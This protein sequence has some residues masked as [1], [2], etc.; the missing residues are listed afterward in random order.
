M[1][2]LLTTLTLGLVACLTMAA[3]LEAEVSAVENADVA[4]SDDLVRAKK[5]ADVSIKL[6]FSI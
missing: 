3:P 5:N 2:F 6:N 1:K 4:V